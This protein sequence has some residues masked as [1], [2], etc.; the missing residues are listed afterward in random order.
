MGCLL[1]FTAPPSRDLPLLSYEHLQ[2]SIT[3]YNEFKENSGYVGLT[4]L[5]RNE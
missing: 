3:A 5:V 1:N 2:T 4:I